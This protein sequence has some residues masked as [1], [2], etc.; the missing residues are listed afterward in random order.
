[1]HIINLFNV[2]LPAVKTLGKM[3]NLKQLN[4]SESGILFSS[5]R[6]DILDALSGAVDL[7]IANDVHGPS[8][9]G[10]E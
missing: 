10:W 2:V 7:L 9:L 5:R 1:V 3:T 6:V 4:I 8:D